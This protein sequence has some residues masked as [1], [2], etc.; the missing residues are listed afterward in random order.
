M[1][2]WWGPIKERLASEETEVTKKNDREEAEIQELV[3]Q[4]KVLEKEL[5]EFS[6]FLET[7]MFFL[8]DLELHRIDTALYIQ[9]TQTH[10]VT[11]YKSITNEIETNTAIQQKNP[12]SRN[13]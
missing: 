11:W 4:E 8:K 12:N 7:Q 10:S 9:K 2:K 3:E 5:A 6:K 13:R 1:Q